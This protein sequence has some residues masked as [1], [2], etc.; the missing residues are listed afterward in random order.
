M[1]ILSFTNSSLALQCLHISFPNSIHLQAL[2]FKHCGIVSW[3][4]K[5]LDTKSEPVFFIYIYIFPHLRIFHFINGTLKT[6]YAGNTLTD[7]DIQRTVH[8]DMFL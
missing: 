7:F 6:Y 8:C 1:T 2:Q 4:Q 3:D 5:Q